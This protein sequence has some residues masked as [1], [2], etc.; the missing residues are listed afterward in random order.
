MQRISLDDHH[1]TNLCSS[2][3]LHIVSSFAG[4]TMNGENK[5]VSIT[6]CLSKD[7]EDM[8]KEHLEGYFFHNMESI[9]DDIN[10]QC[11]Q[12]YPRMTYSSKPFVVF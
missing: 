6:Q 11:L 5:Q 1:E 9:S 12:L 2:D 8:K 4:L 3:I 10:I 7:F